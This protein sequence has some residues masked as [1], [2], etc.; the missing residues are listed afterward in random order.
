MQETESMM[1]ILHNL[2]EDLRNSGESHVNHIQ[3]SNCLYKALDGH[4]KAVQNLVDIETIKSN[5]ISLVYPNR[6]KIFSKKK[7]N[8]T[9]VHNNG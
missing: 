1:I 9:C 5:K 7:R 2:I 8:E 4:Y 3:F 6:F